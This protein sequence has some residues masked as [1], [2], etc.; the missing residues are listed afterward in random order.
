MLPPISV[1]VVED[2]RDWRKLVRL[3]LLVRPEWQIICEVSDGSEAVQKAEEL[4]PDLILLDI[5]LPK[6]NG[7]EAARRIRQLSPNSKIIFL[8]QETSLDI[9]QVALSTGAQ[10]YVYKAGVQSDLLPAMDAVV[11]GEQFVSGTLR[12]YKLTDTLGRKDP[13]HHEVLFYSDDGTFLDGFTRFIAAALKA[14]SAAIVIATKLHRE[15]LLQRL[16]A[17]SVDVDGAIQQGMYISLD[18]ADTLN[19][20]MVD[21]LPDPILFFEG[22]TGLIEAAS[23]AAKGEYPRVAFCG[24]RVGLL[25]VEG[26]TDAAIRL[27]QLCNDLTR[28]HD[29]DILCAYPLSSFRG[30]EDGHD[31]RNIC[32]KHSAVHSR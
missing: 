29:V 9:V 22:I 5:G 10:G 32:S 26:R 18:A 21:G 8:S 2:H 15:S 14:G 28:T 25:W 23:K 7:I 16:K 20:I 19:T 3:L 31:F 12:G 13:H 24:E 17:E 11:R 4:R 1:L 30:E 6:L 27:E